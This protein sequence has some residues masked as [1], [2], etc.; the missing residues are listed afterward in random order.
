MN[1]N[2]F[3]VVIEDV[4]TYDFVIEVPDDYTEE[5]AH[6]FAE[7]YCAEHRDECWKSGEEQIVKFT[8]I[9]GGNNG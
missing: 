1:T 9:K 6:S 2:R 3:H 7:D 5:D 8:Q 4:Q